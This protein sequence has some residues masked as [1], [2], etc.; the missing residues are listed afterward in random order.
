MING[1]FIK[2]GRIESAD[3]STYFDL[4]EGVINANKGTFVGY[5]KTSFIDLAESDA[6]Y[7]TQRDIYVMRDNLSLASSGW[8]GDGYNDRIELPDDKKYIGARV[9]VL[10]TR[11]PPYTRTPG[12]TAP[13][14]IKVSPLARSEQRGILIYDENYYGGLFNVNYAFQFVGRAVEL[15]CAPYRDDKPVWVLVSSTEG[16]RRENSPSFDD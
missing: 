5:I 11:F 13:T 9:I 12:S 16:I 7:D 10:N 4:D 3:G 8:N 15:I 2:T 1:R 6:I 14:T